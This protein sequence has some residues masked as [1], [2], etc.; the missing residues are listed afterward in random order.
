MN[1][2]F[3]P[4]QEVIWYYAQRGGWNLICPIR[5]KVVKVTAKRV[6]VEAPL[7]KGGTKL[8][9]AHPDKLKAV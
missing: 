7:R 6:Q 1:S 8:A 2:E 4:G 9:W 3:T 5:C